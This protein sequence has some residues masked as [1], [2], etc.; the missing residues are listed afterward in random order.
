MPTTTPVEFPKILT[1]KDWQKQKGVLAKL[2]VGETGIGAQMKKV[3]ALFNKVDWTKFY[4]AAIAAK[5]S[6]AVAVEQ[7]KKQMEEEFKKSVIP[8]RPELKK[9]EDLARDA[10]VV[11]KKGK[12]IPKSST[13]HVKEIAETAKQFSVVLQLS[14]PYFIQ[15]QKEFDVLARLQQDANGLLEEKVQQRENFNKLTLETTQHF[16]GFLTAAQKCLKEG[17]GSLSKT[18]QIV[19]AAEREL[20]DFNN[21]PAFAQSRL[22]AK[23][24]PTGVPETP[25]AKRLRDESS[26]LFTVGMRMNKEMQQ[27]L[28]ETREV[29]QEHMSLAEEEELKSSNAEQCLKTLTSIRGDLDRLIKQVSELKVPSDFAWGKVETALTKMVEGY[30]AKKKIDTEAGTNTATGFKK[31]YVD[32]R[33]EFREKMTGSATCVK[34]AGLLSKRAGQ[35]PSLDKEVETA[36]QKLLDDIESTVTLP[37]RMADAI[38]GLDK[39]AKQL[40]PRVAD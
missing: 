34:T 37:R 16:K 19:T 40:N 36:K 31:A 23:A 17:A 6:K 12:L 30:E 18:Q 11:F 39:L 7:L 21:N 8:I 28:A 2:S 9:L 32:K 29:L 4:A 33:D 13:A 22:S 20:K 15:V 14:S 38:G 24:W 10:E 26:T 25:D 27:Y 5:Q 35:V 1:D 3:D